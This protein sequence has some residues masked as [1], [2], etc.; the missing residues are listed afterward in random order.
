MDKPWVYEIQVEGHIAGRWYEWFEGLT[1]D[2][3]PTNQTMLCGTLVDQAA[4]FGVLN[5]I[6]S[7]NLNLVSVSRRTDLTM[8]STNGEV[9]K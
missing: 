4:L 3:S 6:H 7:L 1:I 2:I 9:Q 5:K 8:N